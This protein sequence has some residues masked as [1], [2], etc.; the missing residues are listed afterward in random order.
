M[1]HKPAKRKPRLFDRIAAILEEARATVVRTVNTRMVIAYWLIGREIVQEE[2]G[3][4]RRAGYGDA[5]LEDLSRRL[6]ERYGKGYSVTNLK[7]FRTFYQVYADRLPAIRHSTSDESGIRHEVPGELAADVVPSANASQEITCRKSHTTCGESS[8]GVD[9]PPDRSAPR[10]TEIRQTVSDELGS[11]ARVGFA[12]QLSW[13][14][15]RLLMRV[16][17]QHARAFY[18]VE[19]IH[20]RWKVAD[21]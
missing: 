21:L 5:V 20:E 13:T 16:E 19:A 18:E 9:G 10:S 11:G 3:G 14:H 8:E 17:N 1:T 2:Q 6:T 4:K 7:N 12:P 15:Y